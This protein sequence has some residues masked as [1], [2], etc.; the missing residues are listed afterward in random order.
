MTRFEYKFK[1]GPLLEQQFV[2]QRTMAHIF[3]VSVNAFKGWGLPHT[4]REGRDVWYDWGVATA[5]RCGQI[6]ASKRKLKLSRVEELALGWL[7]ME[8]PERGDSI[9]PD[10]PKRFSKFAGLAGFDRDA[11]ILAL[12]RAAQIIG[13]KTRNRG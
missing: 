13:I 9:Q 8:C 6:S 12:G 11:A 2:N 4:L 10:A 7:P 3:G 1:A 5:A